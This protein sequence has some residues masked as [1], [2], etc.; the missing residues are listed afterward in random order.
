MFVRLQGFRRWQQSLD[1]L[2]RG[3]SGATA[4]EY[5]LIATLVSVAILGALNLISS[6][7]SNTFNDISNNI[8]SST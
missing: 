5:A 4:I 2:K 1:R 6:D 7:M 8:S 3:H